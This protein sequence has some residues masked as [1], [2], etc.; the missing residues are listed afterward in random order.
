LLSALAPGIACARKQG[1][2]EKRHRKELTVLG[3]SREQHW[4]D[5]PVDVMAGACAGMIGGFVA[6]WAMQ[7]FQQATHPQRV[8]ESE[9]RRRVSK[10]RL[11]ERKQEVEQQQ[12]VDKQATTQVAQKLSRNLFDHE[13][14]DKEQE[15]A[16]PTV[17]FAYGTIVGGLYGALSEMWPI[18]DVGFGMGYGVALWALGEEIAVPALRLAPPPTQASP[19]QH[20]DGLAAHL[21]YGI[22]LDVVR[23]VARDVL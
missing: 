14:S 15:L 4:Y 13:L 11:Q 17:S 22:T 7:R 2:Q 21:I 8:A 1:V 23:R 5:K 20:A 18:A 10:E 6:T 9:R 3:F 19:T 16:A 12:E